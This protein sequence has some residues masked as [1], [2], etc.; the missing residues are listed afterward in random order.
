[1]KIRILEKITR[2]QWLALWNCS[3][4]LII[5][6]FIRKGLFHDNFNV[7]EVILY[8]SSKGL[9]LD[10][11]TSHLFGEG[12]ILNTWTTNRNGGSLDPGIF[13]LILR[14]WS[15]FSTQTIWIRLL[16]MCFFLLSIYI[17]NKVLVNKYKSSFSISLVTIL[18]LLNPLITNYA[19]TLRPYSMEYCGIIFLFSLTSLPTEEL[20]KYKKLVSLLLLF[21]LGSRYT[22]WF[23]FL[24][25]ISITLF[26]LNNK[27][28]KRTFLKIVALPILFM[29]FDISI[30]TQYQ[31]SELDFNYATPYFIFQNPSKI[32]DKIIF[33]PF[34]LFAFSYPFYYLTVKKDEKVS[35]QDNKLALFIILS[36]CTYLLLDLINISPFDLNER[37]TL[38]FHAISIFSIALTLGD[39]VNDLGKRKKAFFSIIFS[40]FAILISRN[41]AVEPQSDI[42]QIV[43][44]IANNKKPTDLIICDKVSY[45]M[46]M[47]LKNVARIDINWNQM[48]KFQHSDNYSI[49]SLDPYPNYAHF[50]TTNSP[51]DQA[52]FRDIKNLSLLKGIFYQ[53]L[54]GPKE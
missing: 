47:Y 15:K 29:L 48:P 45:M 9:G 19:F 14:F 11:V 41:F 12:S 4:L 28:E 36:C 17:M 40:V 2:E 10:E 18:F 3:F 21:F 1:M 6:V 20:F 46:I 8:F 52:F 44:Y 35:L 32:W 16:P 54:Y 38:G 49:R 42:I 30:T 43:R 26:S 33:N 27:Y 25:Y 31:F 5:L 51:S 53:R 39:I 7:D 13:T 24:I 34:F 50:L 23:I 37:F 22:I